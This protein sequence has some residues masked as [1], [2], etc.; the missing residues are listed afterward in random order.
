MEM[1]GV[2][3]P[4]IKRV[5]KWFDDRDMHDPK[6]QLNKVLEETGEIAHEITRNRYDTPELVDAIGDTMVTVLGLCHHLN[7]DPVAALNAA[8]VEIEGRKGK[9]IN[10]SFVKNE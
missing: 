7:I 4:L 6:A 10:G 5:F 3:D 9:T 2:M 8:L 1:V